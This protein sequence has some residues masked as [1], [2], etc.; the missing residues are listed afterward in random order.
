M[1]CVL[2][3]MCRVSGVD[4]KMDQL[5]HKTLHLLVANPAGQESLLGPVVGGRVS[6]AWVPVTSTWVSNKPSTAM[7]SR[8]FPGSKIASKAPQ[9][10]Q[11]R[12][13]SLRC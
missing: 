4:L 3:V 1:C 6:E 11:R 7:I 5:R 13:C 9:R 12:I 8:S 10:P 2:C